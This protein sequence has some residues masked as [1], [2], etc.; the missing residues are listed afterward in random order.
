MTMPWIS[1]VWGGGPPA[2]SSNLHSNN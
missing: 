2:A 1:G